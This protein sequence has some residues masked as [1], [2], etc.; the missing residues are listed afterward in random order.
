MLGSRTLAGLVSMLMFVGRGRGSTMA[1]RAGLAKGVARKMNIEC[2]VAHIN[3]DGSLLR[4]RVESKC[5]PGAEGTTPG[6]MTGRLR[7]TVFGRTRKGSTYMIVLARRDAILGRC[8]VVRLWVGRMPAGLLGSGRVAGLAGVSSR[9]A[10]GRSVCVGILRGILRVVLRCGR[11]LSV[12]VGRPPLGWTGVMIH[13][14][15]RASMSIERM[16]TDI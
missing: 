6:R 1:S 11:R 8:L 5:E 14:R 13:Y 4:L 10:S 12:V 16:Q 3:K 9:G 2:I 7:A 15:D